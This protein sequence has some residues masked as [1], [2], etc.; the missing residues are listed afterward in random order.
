MVIERIILVVIHLPGSHKRIYTM[1]HNDST[2][3]ELRGKKTIFNGGV[4]SAL[5]RRDYRVLWTGALVSNIGTWVHTAALL[6]FV[7]SITDSNSWVGAVNLA[8][9]LPVLLFSF[10]A[11][12]LAD[13]RDRKSLIIWSQV[14]MMLG[15]FTLGVLTWLEHAT[16]PSI[17]TITAVMGTAFAFNFPA[18]QALLP[19]LVPRDDLMNAVALSAAQFNL[20]RFLGPLLGGVIVIWSV[21]AAFFLNSASFLFVIGALL[22]IKTATPGY[23]APAEGI[24]V[25]IKEGLTF[26]RRRRWMVSML[27]AIGVASFFGLSVLVLMPSI[28]RDVLHRGPGAYWLLLGM[29]GGGAVMSAPLVTYLGGRFPERNIVKACALGLG[30]SIIALSFSR[31][32]WLSCLINVALGGS[33]LMMSASI[34][35]ALQGKITREIRGRVMALYIMSMVGAFPIGG[36]VQGIIADRTS[37]PTALLVGGCACVAMAL[38]LTCFPGLTRE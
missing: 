14:V 34:N 23:P 26:V 4:L 17:I 7:K 15:A 32:Y 18:W 27:V 37:T 38:V 3:R 8:S 13:Y 28:A 10:I 25:H 19:D 35:T 24:W 29:M 31:T 6:W 33:F 11:G 21:A 22:L 1:V 5:G 20:A 9:Y 12:S 30:L 36:Q 16:L 2:S